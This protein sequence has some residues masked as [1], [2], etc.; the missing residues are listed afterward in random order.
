M[1]GAIRQAFDR[2]V[3][4]ETEI[5]RPRRADWPAASRLVELEQRAAMF[6]VDRLVVRKRLRLGVDGLQH[7]ILQPRRRC[8]ARS[9][10]GSLD[11]SLGGALARRAP[12]VG[13]LF[14]RQIKARELAD[15]GVAA[16]ANMG[17]DFAAG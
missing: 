13:A 1:A 4:A 3:A 11:A 9:P 10:D 16:D 2:C 17:G 8:Q 15:D 6:I 14:P 5:L 7:L 12:F